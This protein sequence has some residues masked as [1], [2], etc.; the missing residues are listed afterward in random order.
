MKIITGNKNKQQEIKN[1]IK[2]IKVN[3]TIEFIEEDLK[4]VKGNNIEIIIYK[5]K[6]ALKLT[7]D[8]FV[9]EDITMFVNNTFVPDIKWRQDELKDGDR[10]QIILTIAK[11]DGEYL[12][13]YEKRIDGIICL[14]KCDRYDFGFDNVVFVNNEKPLGEYKEEIPLRKIYKDILMGDIR[15]EYKIKLSAVPEWKGEYQN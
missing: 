10:I 1:V 3:D 2:D 6:E 9:I 7:D 8:N 15:P 14:N 12:N 11:K 4:E 5:A 13:I